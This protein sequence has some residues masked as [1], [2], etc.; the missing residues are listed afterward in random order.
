M[1]TNHN[2]ELSVDELENAMKR[3]KLLR[4]GGVDAVT[5][6]GSILKSSDIRAD[7]RADVIKQRAKIL[8]GR[9]YAHTSD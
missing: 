2:G 6:L 5:R 8:K 9:M 1:D 4:R 7:I 3:A